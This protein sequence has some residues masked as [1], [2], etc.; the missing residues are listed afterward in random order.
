MEPILVNAF[1]SQYSHNSFSWRARK[2]Q[3][4]GI[5]THCA[6]HYRKFVK[7][8]I[9]VRRKSISAPRWSQLRPN[10]FQRESIFRECLAKGFTA[11][12][13]AFTMQCSLSYCNQKRKVDYTY[14][15]VK[16]KTYKKYATSIIVKFSEDIIFTALLTRNKSST[17]FHIFIFI[18]LA[19]L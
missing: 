12:S 6:V 10:C 18:L 5:S 8:R 9:A 17:V 14:S 16:A 7:M 11:D 19:S 3:W 2:K 4:R 13:A 1:Y 15:R